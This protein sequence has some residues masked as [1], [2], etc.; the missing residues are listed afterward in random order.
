MNRTP[1]LVGAV[2]LATVLAGQTADASTI[3]S[4]DT[5]ALAAAET[6]YAKVLGE[7]K[8]GARGSPS[9]EPPWPS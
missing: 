3:T 2:A 8:P 9:T 5:K 1:L 6:A 4:T 7:Y